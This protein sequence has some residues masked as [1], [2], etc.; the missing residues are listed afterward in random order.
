MT[1]NFKEPSSFRVICVLSCVTCVYHAQYLIITHNTLSL[2]TIP[3]HYLV[4]VHV[5]IC[6]YH[7]CV[8][9]CITRNTHT[10]LSSCLCAY[11]YMCVCVCVYICVCVCVCIYVCVS[12]CVYV[13]HTMI[14]CIYVYTCITHITSS[15]SCLCV[16]VCIRVSHNI[17][18]HMRTH[19]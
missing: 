17:C 16:Y 11:V 1:C 12:V 6:V 3:Y 7:M 14:V 9:V 10:S 13:Y 4:S 15:P 18:A 8:Y 2:R 19:M 5:C